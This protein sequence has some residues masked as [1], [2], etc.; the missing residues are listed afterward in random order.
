MTYK[1]PSRGSKRRAGRHCATVQVCAVV[2]LS[3]SC[4]APG[5][6][7]AAV[8][9]VQPGHQLGPEST[10][11][12]A[13]VRRLGCNNGSTGDVQEFSVRAE[14]ESVVVTFYV[15]PDPSDASCPG[16]DETPVVVELFE[17]LGDRDLVDGQCSPDGPASGSK[18]CRP[19][20]VRYT[21]G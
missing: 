20:G 12:T 5:P 1:S 2:L 19:D 13:M 17:P 16:N 10:T 6:G 15:E 14:G 9:T 3:S 18:Y 4:S 7:D 21:P 8:W 11:F